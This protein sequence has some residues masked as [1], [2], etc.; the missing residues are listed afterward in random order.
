MQLSDTARPQPS[1]V[2]FAALADVSCEHLG[3]DHPC[4][5]LFKE[6]RSTGDA[7]SVNRALD[8]LD[9]LPEVPRTHI[10]AHAKLRVG[11]SDRVLDWVPP[12]HKIPSGTTKH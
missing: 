8:A 5:R 1:Q 4:S 12:Q 2:H 7:D 6:A 10:K 9:A 11:K 3:S